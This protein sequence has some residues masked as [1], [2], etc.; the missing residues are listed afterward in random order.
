MKTCLFISER[1]PKLAGEKFASA[2]KELSLDISEEISCLLVFISFIIEPIADWEL[3]DK[4]LII[5]GRNLFISLC[6]PS[7]TI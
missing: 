4:V 5:D 7:Y 1:A 3:F 2:L 6:P